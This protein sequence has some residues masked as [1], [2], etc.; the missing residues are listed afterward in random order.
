MRDDINPIRPSLLSLLTDD[1]PQRQSESEIPN[2]NPSHIVESVILDLIHLLNSRIRS[3]HWI[4]R[5]REK[6]TPWDYGLPDFSGVDGVGRNELVSNWVANTIRHFEPRLKSV[7]V[8][9]VPPRE[10]SSRSI[11]VKIE[12]ELAIEPF[13][14]LVLTSSFESSTGRFG[15]SESKE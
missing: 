8:V 9:G 4:D 1:D 2:A 10:G 5:G 15:L 13:Q 11:T 12:A 3:I 6:G 14:K 7:E